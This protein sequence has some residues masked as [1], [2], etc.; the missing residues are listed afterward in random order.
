MQPVDRDPQH[1][2]LYSPRQGHLVAAKKTMHIS[3]HERSLFQR[4]ASR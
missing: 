3:V 4:S 2:S 1:Y